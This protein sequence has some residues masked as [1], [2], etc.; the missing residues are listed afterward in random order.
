[1]QSPQTNQNK[2]KRIAQLRKLIAYHR[3]LYHAKDQPE[4]SDEAYDSLVNELR[5]LEGSGDDD[6]SEATVIGGSINE[7]FAKVTHTVPQWSLGNVFTDDELVA[8]EER[9]ERHLASQDIFDVQLTYEV[10]YKLDGLKVILTYEAGRLVQGA[11]RG[12]G[13]TGED[14]THT[15]STIKTI[16]KQLKYPIDLICVGEVMLHKDDFARINKARAAAG[17]SL[18]AN[19]RNAAAGSVRQLDPRVTA[20]RNLRYYAYDIDA[21]DLHDTDLEKPDSQVAEMKLLKKLG[22]IINPESVLCKSIAEVIKYY[23]HWKKKHESLPYGVDGVV[24]KVNDLE[25]QRRLGFT[26]KSPRYAIAYKFPATQAT[27]VVE[28][29]QLQ[30]GRTGVVTPV[31]HLTPVLIDGSTVSRATLH[32]E[33]QIKRLDVRIGDTVVIQ[34]AGDII[35]EIVSVI[36]ELR[37]EKTQPYRFPKKVEGCGGDGSIERKPGEAAYRCVTLDSDQLH[38]ERLYYFV[39]KQALNIDGLGPRIIDLLLDEG[40][41]KN[42]HDLFTLKIG[43]L[44]DLP[45]FKEKA[46]Q[47]LINAI[48][49]ARYVPLHRLLIGLSIEHVGEET[50]RLIASHMGTIDNIRKASVADLASIHGVGDVV[51]ASVVKWFSDKKNQQL[52]D[53]LLPWLRIVAPQQSAATTKLSGKNIV[54]TGTLPTL[55]RD[56]AKDIARRA[57]AHVASSVSKQT[58]YVVCGEEAGSKRSKAE[59]LGVAILDE[60]EFI[61]MAGS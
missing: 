3:E 13:V 51:A 35:P 56:E 32:N 52:L 9:L 16:P 5:Q 27:S 42:Y 20:A 33:D 29:I 4:I 26:A 47:N 6:V 24:V 21:Y 38:R 59:A 40:L 22:L 30:V 48:E 31:A 50:A 23:N 7:A 49:A 39:S 36:L 53:Q 46:A 10:G 41:I 2:A 14:V 18:F 58:D 37:P 54:F 15:V 34:K 28:D 57:G 45:G 12:D 11:T 55:T 43:D 60:S 44:K 17:E 61:K 8:W 19:P 25:I 1:M